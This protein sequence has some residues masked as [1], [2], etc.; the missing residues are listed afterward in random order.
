[1]LADMSFSLHKRKNAQGK[2]L[3][4]W[5][6]FFRTPDP[7]NPDKLKVILLVI[8]QRRRVMMTK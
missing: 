4:H 8:L 6:A 1:M 2:E 5:Y 7:G 3:P